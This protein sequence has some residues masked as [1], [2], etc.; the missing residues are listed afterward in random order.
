[1]ESILRTD[2]DFMGRPTL[3]S[4]L[5]SLKRLAYW[6]ALRKVTKVQSIKVCESEKQSNRCPGVAGRGVEFS[7]PYLKSNRGITI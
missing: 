4:V 5:G 7:K 2:S 1:M 3:G 6:A